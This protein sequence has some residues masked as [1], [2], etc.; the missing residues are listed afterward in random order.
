MCSECQGDTQQS[1][2]GVA[3]VFSFPRPRPKAMV[4]GDGKKTVFCA[5][6]MCARWGNVTVADI[7][8]VAHWWSAVVAFVRTHIHTYVIG[9]VGLLWKP[10][11]TD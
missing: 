8:L 6:Y 10:A 9:V 4:F 11:P 7:M 5:F 3:G 2:T 1:I